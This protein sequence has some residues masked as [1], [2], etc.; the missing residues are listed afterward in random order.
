VEQ[1]AA[2]DEAALEGAEDRQRPVAVAVEALGQGLVTSSS[3]TDTERIAALDGSLAERE[4][5]L[6]VVVS[7]PLTVEDADFLALSA[8]VDAGLAQVQCRATG[9]AS[10]P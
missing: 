1:G 10:T 7:A 3:F 9:R 5:E 8:S 6:A 2:E 4:P